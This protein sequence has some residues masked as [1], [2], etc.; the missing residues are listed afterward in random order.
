MSSQ[1]P[2]LVALR[3]SIGY[4]VTNDIYKF[5]QNMSETDHSEAPV[6]SQSNDSNTSEM[7]TKLE[8]LT[9]EVENLQE[10]FERLQDLDQSNEIAKLEEKLIELEKRSRDE[11]LQVQ[12]NDLKRRLEYIV[13]RSSSGE[14]LEADSSSGEELEAD[15]SSDEE[16]ETD[17]SSDE[18]QETDSSSGEEDLDGGTPQ[19]LRAAQ[20]TMV[21][22]QEEKK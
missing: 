11:K 15:S 12:I 17:S 5:S 16:Q 10:A 20:A 21:A 19:W 1:H 22:T 8:D 2:S 14:E 6:T 4:G 9:E 13:S 18:E 7:A 3:H